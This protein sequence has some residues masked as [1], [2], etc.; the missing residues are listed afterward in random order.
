MKCILH[1]FE[2]SV[3]II[4]YTHQVNL[5]GG[6]CLMVEELPFSD[7]SKSSLSSLEAEVL[8]RSLFRGAIEA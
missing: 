7:V 4:I 3:K 8:E 1:I 2:I 5:V 6:R